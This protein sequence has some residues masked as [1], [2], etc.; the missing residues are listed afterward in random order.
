MQV[1]ETEVWAALLLVSSTRW[2]PCNSRPLVTVYATS[3]AC[4]DSHLRMAGSERTPTTGCATLIHGRS[5]ALT[6]RS[7]SNLIAR[8]SC[9][10][11]GLRSFPI[12]LPACTEYLLIVRS[13][14]TEGRRLT[15]FVF[16]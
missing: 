8:S 16:G 11:D 9:A 10:T 3:M 6:K 13:W 15:P 1:W 14:V 4:F 12:D 7:R 2:P 5:A